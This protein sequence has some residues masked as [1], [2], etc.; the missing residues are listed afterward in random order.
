[1]TG[2]TPLHLQCR[3][4]VSNRHLIHTTVARRTADAFVYMNAVVEISVVGQ[5][6]YPNPLDRFASAKAGAHWFKIRAVSPDLLVAIHARV[7]G[8]HASGRRCFYR[9]MAVAAINAI[10]S[11][12]M[13]VAKL[14]GLL[15]LNPLAGVPG[16]TVQLNCYPQSGKENKD[17]AINRQLG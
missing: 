13:F 7:R 8:G 10:V 1:M 5:V 12:V 16:R 17:S 15:S 2:K 14:D 4:L 11:H 9:G 3:R 6:M